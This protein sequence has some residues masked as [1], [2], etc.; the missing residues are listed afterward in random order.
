[1]L[2]NIKSA[3]PEGKN[4]IFDYKQNK[5]VILIKKSTPVILYNNKKKY[6]LIFKN[7]IQLAKFIGCNKCTVNKYIKSG[8]CYK[9]LYYF[10]I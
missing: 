7:N 6:I 4:S 10:K 1:M 2:Y 5:I 9:G 3:G 8:K